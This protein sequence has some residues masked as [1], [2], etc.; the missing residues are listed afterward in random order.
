MLL[1][2]CDQVNL[3]SIGLPKCL[4]CN[5][6]FFYC[7]HIILMFSFMVTFL[8]FFQNSTRFI[9]CI[10]Y[11]PPFKNTTALFL[12]QSPPPPS[13]TFL[14]SQ[15]IVQFAS[16]ACP[17]LKLENPIFLGRKMKFRKLPTCGYKGR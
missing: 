15:L 8:L 1:I 7:S 14:G 10:G 13:P 4:L 16:A 6:F 3:L 2:R 5:F 17:N 12:V 9:V 11:Q